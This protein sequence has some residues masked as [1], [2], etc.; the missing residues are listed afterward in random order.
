M[1]PSSSDDSKASMN[2]NESTEPARSKV[3]DGNDMW[4]LSFLIQMHQFVLRV[5]EKCTAI[6][7]SCAAF[8]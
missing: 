6:S 5:T 8:K 1:Q 4:F 3:S 2:T 7:R